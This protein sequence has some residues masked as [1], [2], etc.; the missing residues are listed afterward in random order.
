[1]KVS[2]DL[3]DTLICYQESVPREPNRVPWPLKFWLDEPLRLGSCKLFENLKKLGCEIIIYTTSYRSSLRVC[4]WLFFY[5]LY[6]KKVINQT[7][8]DKYLRDNS[9]AYRI[10]KN[11][12]IFGIDLHIDDSE[13]VRLEGERYGFN[14]VVVSPD[15]QNWHKKV[16]DAVLHSLQLQEP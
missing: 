5:G 2:F 8:Y 6:V 14:V 4:L 13:G 11:P 9:N 12:K 3:D 7:A 15:D 16:L 10:S 1:M